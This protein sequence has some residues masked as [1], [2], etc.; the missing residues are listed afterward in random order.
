MPPPVSDLSCAR[1]SSPNNDGSHVQE[2]LFHSF[3]TIEFAAQVSCG[4]LG[5]SHMILH[6]P[7]LALLLAIMFVGC[8]KPSVHP[9]LAGDDLEPLPYWNYGAVF[10]DSAIGLE[11]WRVWQGKQA[12]LL[13]WYTLHD[14]NG[15]MT[16]A[17]FWITFVDI[18]RSQKWALLKMWTRDN[19]WRR[20]F[21]VDSYEH[22]FQV[23]DH[24]PTNNDID[25]SLSRFWRYQA[26]PPDERLL[27]G[28]VRQATWRKCIGAP[29]NVVY[30][31][32][33]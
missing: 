32:S 2:Q 23:F 3:C 30:K 14:R 17:L 4:Q 15:N 21:V 16:E 26:W 9:L 27:E 22:G 12:R 7:Y 20:A 5:G 1:T 11:D 24:P 6:N 25:E 8:A 18:R 33:Q 31:I 28:V 13:T 10:A 29:S 19:S